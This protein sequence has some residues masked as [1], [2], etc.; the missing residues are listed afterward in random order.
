MTVTG[1]LDLSWSFIPVC[2]PEATEK[3]VGVAV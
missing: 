1:K 3:S 2:G